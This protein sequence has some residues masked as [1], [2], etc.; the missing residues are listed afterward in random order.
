MIPL[1]SFYMEF[2]FTKT[3]YMN[4]FHIAWNNPNEPLQHDLITLIEQC[5]SIT[6][7]H[8]EKFY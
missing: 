1:V 2:L 6:L 4:M 3:P 8:Q 5:A 7:L